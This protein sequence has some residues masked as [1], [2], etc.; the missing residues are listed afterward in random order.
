MWGVGRTPRSIPAS[1]GS[2]RGS[3]ECR[4]GEERRGERRIQTSLPLGR[5]APPS[6]P[7]S[8]PARSERRRQRR[9]PRGWGGGEGAGSG[10]GR[11]GPGGRR[12]AGWA[13]PNAP[14][15]DGA[16][17]TT[18]PTRQPQPP[19]V[20]A[21]STGGGQDVCPTGG[22][23]RTAPGVQT[24]EDASRRQRER[25]GEGG[26]RAAGGRRHHGRR[27]REG[28]R[29]PGRGT[30]AGG[31]GISWRPPEIRAGLRGE[32]ERE[33]R[34]RVAAAERQH[35]PFLAAR[36]RKGEGG[37]K[38]SAA[39]L[40]AER[41]RP[42]PGPPLSAGPN[43]RVIASSRPNGGGGGRGAALCRA[44]A[45]RGWW[46]CGAAAANYNSALRGAVFGNFRNRGGEE[47]NAVPATLGP[48]RIRS[49]TN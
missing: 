29:G 48:L 17:R 11:A 47:S 33:A 43:S 44:P 30:E 31:K 45:R 15:A 39:W 35:S 26:R 42:R 5:A 32:R 16:E 49:G 27:R 23:R 25:L 13:E 37:R 28:G 40:P 7:G 8:R 21:A 24:E 4:R 36:E 12:G 3:G 46:G 18:P 2:K 14:A 19:P 38:V 1:A 6:P 41:G 22:E 9:H 20:V 10:A 34:R